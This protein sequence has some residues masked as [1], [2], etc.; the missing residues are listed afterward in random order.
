MKIS[1][2]SWRETDRKLALSNY[3]YVTTYTRSFF[4]RMQSFEG[5]SLQGNVMGDQPDEFI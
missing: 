3:N 2:L 4:T 5:F 1:R